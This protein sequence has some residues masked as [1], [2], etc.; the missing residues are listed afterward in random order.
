MTREYSGGCS[1]GAVRFRTR[2][3]PGPVVGCHC[4]Q[5]RR[6]TG[7]YYASCDVPL[8]GLTLEGEGS[9]HWYQSSPEAKRGFCLNCGSAL[10]WQRAGSAHVSVLAGAFD[11]AVG[12][13]FGY[14]IFCADKPGFYQ[15]AG[16]V[17][18][19]PQAAD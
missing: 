4:S 12:L 13:R 3:E 9:I 5:S 2:A 17:P 14:H 11:S 19:F 8:E 15:I 16:D 7:L 10:F 6:Q 1:C 18:H